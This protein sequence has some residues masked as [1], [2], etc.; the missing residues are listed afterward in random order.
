MQATETGQSAIVG[1]GKAKTNL[2]SLGT[3]N[4]WN[5]MII[6]LSVD[7]NMGAWVKWLKRQR[8]GFRE[9]MRVDCLA[10]PL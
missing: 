4:Q 5:A 7:V 8:P 3:Q 1:R 6:M 10:T 9:R 2:G